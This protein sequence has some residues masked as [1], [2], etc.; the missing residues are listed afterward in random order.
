[1][2]PKSGVEKAPDDAEEH[3]SP[4]GQYFRKWTGLAVHSQAKPNA[5]AR[6]LSERPGTTL[7]HETLAVPFDTCV[8]L[9]GCIRTGIPPS[10]C[11]TTVFN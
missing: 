10:I 11:T 5:V 7:D 6:W 4:P 1:M 3:R 2:N 9:N 8:A